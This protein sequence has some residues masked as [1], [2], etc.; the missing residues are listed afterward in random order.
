[1]DI[2]SILYNLPEVKHPEEKKLS[3]NAKLKWTLIV[4]AAFFILANIAPQGQTQKGISAISQKAQE[5]FG[6]LNF[7]SA[8]VPNATPSGETV[9]S[10]NERALLA[11]QFIGKYPAN[12]TISFNDEINGLTIYGYYP[13]YNKNNLP[14]NYQDDEA[15]SKKIARDFILENKRLLGADENTL[16]KIL[17]NPKL[18][19]PIDSV[20]ENGMILDHGPGT[21][22][23]LADFARKAKTI[24]WNGPLGNYEKGFTDGTDAFARAVADSGARSVIG[25]GDTVAAIEHLGILSR[26]SFVS[27]GGGA[28]L[29]FLARGTLPG[30]EVLD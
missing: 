18:L 27:T 8:N 24:L 3:F 13:F 29:D 16:K 22:A 4:L 11:D 10:S 7:K 12:W 6:I 21:S 2:K 20:I 19:L 5:A 14:Q 23:L 28:M 26:F 25:G 30:I 17:S 1:M 9:F 15:L